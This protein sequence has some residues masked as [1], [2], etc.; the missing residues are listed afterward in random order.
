LRRFR[1]I[2]LLLIIVAVLLATT[3]YASSGVN[4]KE[5]KSVPKQIALLQAQLDQLKLALDE[6]NSK[7]D[8][9]IQNL[10]LQ[11]QNQ[12][13]QIQQLMNEVQSLNDSHT[14]QANTI[15][16]IGTELS[17]LKSTVNTIGTNLDTLK[18]N[19][20][21][22]SSEIH[23]KIPALETNIASSEQNM[24][25]VNNRLKRIEDTLYPPPPPPPPFALTGVELIEV[26]QKPVLTDISHQYEVTYDM[27]LTFNDGTKIPYGQQQKV[28]FRY[29][30]LYA[31]IQ[32]R[33]NVTYEG[34][35]YEF[36]VFPSRSAPPEV[37]IVDLG[38]LC[39]TT[40]ESFRN[41]DGTYEYRGS[42][43][44]TLMMSDGTLRDAYHTYYSDSPLIMT[45]YKRDTVPVPNN[46]FTFSFN[47]QGKQYT[48]TRVLPFRTF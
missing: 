41:S 13:Q 6:K 4:D 14:Q 33:I 25:T 32:T 24:A 29:D 3:A 34:K 15:E 39:Y 1:F 28:L 20:E 31:H 16:S 21:G 45:V 44:F 22:L 23:T 7:Q 27:Y 11:S 40:F 12:K 26:G 37:T 17:N 46:E 19:V 42:F 8:Q 5:E 48:F 47:Y 35:S 18:A 38:V 30:E 43:S 2:L 10:T 36:S 9:A